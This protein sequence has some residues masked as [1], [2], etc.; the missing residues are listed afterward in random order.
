MSKRHYRYSA[1]VNGQ[2]RTVEFWAN[3]EDWG[4]ES[5]PEDP[6][7]LNLASAELLID[8]EFATYKAFYVDATYDDYNADREH[9]RLEVNGWTIVEAD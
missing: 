5:Y 2:R 6:A 3:P 1:D 8:N 4:H 7:E 9:A